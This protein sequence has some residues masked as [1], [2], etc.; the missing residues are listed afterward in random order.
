MNN[1]PASKPGDKDNEL[2]L[3]PLGGA[4]EIGMNLYLYG[5]GPAHD[6]QWLAVDVGVTF[7][8]E[9]EPG[10][11]LV[12]PDVGFIEE[13]RQ[14]LVGIVL[15]HAHED[16]FGALVELWPSLR[17]PVYATPFTAALLRAKMAEF[18]AREQVPL[19]ELPLGSR[20][21]LGRFDLEF[22]GMSHSIPEPNALVIR[23]P[24]GTVCHSGDFKFDPVPMVGAPADKSRL[25]AI[26]DEGVDV[27]ICD[28][29]NV[30]KDGHSASEGRVAE[31]LERLIVNAPQRVVVTAFSSSVARIRSVVLAAKAAG[32]YVVVAGKSLWRVITAARESGHIDDSMTFLDQDQYGY[33]QRDEIVL[34]CT[35][36]QGEPRAALSRMARGEHRE[37]KLA[38]GDMLIMSSFTIPGN[39]RLVGGMLNQL[40]DEGVDIVTLSDD[41]VH[42]SGH[43]QKDELR[44]LYQL[45]RPRTVVPM[46][47]EYRHLREHRKFALASGIP[48]AEL[49]TNGDVMRLLP[50]PVE[51][52]D[53]APTG[54]WYLDGNTLC[55]HHEA[56][57]AARRK[58][59][60]VGVISVSVT[61]ARKSH[62]LIDISAEVHGIPF[63]VCEPDSHENVVEVVIEGVLDSLPKPKKRDAALTQEAI[64]RAIR[65]EFLRRWGKKPVCIVHLAYI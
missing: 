38:E 13:E 20:F 27:L 50:G 47:G 4:G 31:T 32:R 14:S 9:A 43:P 37:I 1:H 7:P 57:L 29:T 22:V 52:I 40:A 34:L 51:K 56:P 28:S 44:D 6:R 60:Y 33:L 11:E 23:T 36:S 30:L 48:N 15:T 46:H 25:Q 17:A 41:L 3:L 63:E 10:M 49:M 59:S 39:E 35:G 55:V 2:V 61:L 21:T 64:R 8:H 18:G 45:L 26:G 58:L 19:H 65:A 16:H 12:F 62:E 42:A 5:Y 54:R 24:E 53:E